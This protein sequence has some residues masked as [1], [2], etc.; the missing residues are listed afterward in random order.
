M[1]ARHR[2]LVDSIGLLALRLG[3]GLLMLGHGWGKLTWLFGGRED[4]FPDPIGLGE[5]ISHIG[6][7]MGEFFGAL[8][9]TL[10]LFTRLAAIP[11]IFTMAVAALVVHSKDPLMMSGAGASKEPALLFLTGF[12]AIACLGP[13]RYSFDTMVVPRV[14]ARR[15]EKKPIQG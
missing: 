15:S 14:R 9:V 11:T 3:F 12:V 10:G 6:A 7:V 8:F 2:D 13:G 4:A 5:T 1:S